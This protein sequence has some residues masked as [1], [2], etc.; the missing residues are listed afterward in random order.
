MSI[1]VHIGAHLKHL[2]RATVHDIETT[3]CNRYHTTTFMYGAEN[4]SFSERWHLQA[5]KRNQ[6]NMM[7]GEEK[8]PLK[9]AKTRV[10]ITT[11]PEIIDQHIE[12]KR[13]EDI[14]TAKA[15][16][17]EGAEQARTGTVITITS[18]AFK[19]FMGRAQRD[20]LL[21][22]ALQKVKKEKF[23]SDDVS[24]PRKTRK[25]GSTATRYLTEL[26]ITQQSTVEDWLKAMSVTEIWYEGGSEALA[27]H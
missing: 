13:K 24:R 5:I 6:V 21:A 1:N 7:M 4:D 20:E 17:A 16:Q 27:Y 25:T 11:D 26:Q 2:A 15:R 10:P 18:V 14:R 8:D 23:T 22:R 12:K 3:R 19:A 9:Y